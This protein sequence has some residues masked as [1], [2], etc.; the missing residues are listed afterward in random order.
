[1]QETISNPIEDI[2][3]K[4]FIWVVRAIY[5]GY[6]ENDEHAELVQELHGAFINQVR[7]N[8]GAYLEQA[9]L[10]YD[11]PEEVDT[12]DISTDFFS[13]MLRD[14][15]HARMISLAKLYAC[16]VQ[17]EDHYELADENG[18]KPSQLLKKELD[19]CLKGTREQL[20]SNCTTKERFSHV[21]GTIDGIPTWAVIKDVKYII[22]KPESIGNPM[23]SPLFFIPEFFK[24]AITLIK[25]EIAF[26]TAATDI[27]G[28]SDELKSE[29]FENSDYHNDL[30]EDIDLAFEKFNQDPKVQRYSPKKPVGMVI[31]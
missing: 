12:S 29:L 25:H 9:L 13:E 8:Y 2:N 21:S 7:G 17:I 23:V 24:D 15:S 6:D 5:E 14:F 28:L 19:S 27:F 18:V 1:M 22:E 11:N 4:D 3:T 31:H 10:A 26:C 20:I 16:L 30:L